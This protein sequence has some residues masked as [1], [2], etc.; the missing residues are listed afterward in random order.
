MS[1]EG[2][3]MVPALLGVGMAVALICL[4]VC[5]TALRQSA[6]SARLARSA[7]LE[8]ATGEV[9]AVVDDGATAEDVSRDSYHFHLFI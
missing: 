6:A 8:L 2:D 5:V 3:V 9:A 7:E 4:A 1:H